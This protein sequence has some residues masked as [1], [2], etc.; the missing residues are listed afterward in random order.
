MQYTVASIVYQ[1]DS[2]A[3]DRLFD[4]LLPAADC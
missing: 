1:L 2:A 3:H 4:L